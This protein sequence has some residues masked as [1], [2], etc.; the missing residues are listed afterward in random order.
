[1]RPNGPRQDGQEGQAADGGEQKPPEAEVSVRKPN[2]SSVPPGLGDQPD[3]DD[4]SR[5][6]RCREFFAA[7]R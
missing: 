6:S 2:G 3:T 1:M 5:T 7:C 4:N